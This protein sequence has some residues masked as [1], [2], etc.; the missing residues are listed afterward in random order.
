[1]NYWVGRSVCLLML[2]CDVLSTFQE[3]LRGI[4]IRCSRKQLAFLIYLLNGQAEAFVK[5]GSLQEV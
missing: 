4:V 5:K 3:H 2:L 1:M